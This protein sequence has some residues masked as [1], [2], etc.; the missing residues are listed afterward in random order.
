MPDEEE[1]T[2]PEL[3]GDP[4][5]V[6][7]D[8]KP[9]GLF[10]WETVVGTEI[11]RGVS[12][13]LALY[14]GNILR[15]LVA[16]SNQPNVSTGAIRYILDDLRH[17][18]PGSNVPATV[19]ANYAS[20]IRSPVWFSPKP[21]KRA[22]KRLTTMTTR[23][24]QEKRKPTKTEFD[25][26]YS[27]WK[28]GFEP[29]YKPGPVIYGE[30]IESDKAIPPV[31]VVSDFHMGAN[32]ATATNPYGKRSSNDLSQ[33]T[34]FAFLKWL[35][36]V[37]QECRFHKYYDVV[38]NGDFV[39]LWQAGNFDSP[40]DDTYRKRL[41]AILKSNSQFFSK[42]RSFLQKH[43]K[44]RFHYLKGNHDDALDPASHGS[45]AGFDDK[46]FKGGSSPASLQKMME[47][48]FA[49]NTHPSSHPLF[50][51]K[52]AF[53]ITKEVYKN[54]KY[55]LHI[56]HGHRFDK[57]N[58]RDGDSEISIGQKLSH[59]TN[60][61][62]EK[63]PSSFREIESTPNQETAKYLK[64]LQQSSQIGTPERAALEKLKDLGISS[65]GSAKHFAD[66]FLPDSV[67][68]NL[69][70]QALDPY[71]A[72]VEY[73]DYA[74][75]KLIKSDG[76]KVVVFGHTHYETLKSAGAGVYANSGSWLDREQFYRENGTYCRLRIIDSDLPYVKIFKDNTRD[77]IVVQLKYYRG[78]K[79]DQTKRVPHKF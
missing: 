30:H 44:C 48:L 61:M 43:P 9:L 78:K 31:Y 63:F 50:G 22:V 32:G 66:V 73:K 25:K 28:P 65:A 14:R 5:V 71:D 58:W 70:I 62:Q 10:N 4:I 7:T 12:A 42:L 51:K 59:H 35:E 34:L 15:E 74:V 64:C 52:A 79:L 1:H 23:R 24:R 18:A 76:P 69:A 33:A 40:D 60:W 6:N 57:A 8:G 75:D 54:D 41:S 26:E 55:S 56:E 72:T 38:M 21:V 46:L 77:E 3:N 16:T 20:V 36:M 49:K 11:A 29:T 2:E 39:D 53:F 67:T 68:S 17:H 27:I 13:E 45:N 37:D 47:T 19:M